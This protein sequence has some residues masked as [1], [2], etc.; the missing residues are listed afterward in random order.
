MKRC[1]VFTSVFLALL[2][3]GCSNDEGPDTP[4]GDLS[5][6]EYVIQDY[7]LSVFNSDLR[8]EYVGGHERICPSAR[9]DVRRMR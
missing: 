3:A 5:T 4:C 1:T 7:T 2:I 9:A 8:G 6:P